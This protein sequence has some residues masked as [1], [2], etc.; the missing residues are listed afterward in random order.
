MKIGLLKTGLLKAFIKKN[1][2]PIKFLFRM[3]ALI[4]LWK[5]LFFITWRNPV[6]LGYYNEFSLLII[7]LLLNASATIMSF[8]GEQMEVDHVLRIIRIKDTV[9]V[10]VGEPCI[11]FEID[12][13]FIALILCS[14]G[15]IQNK[16]WYGTLGLGLLIFVNILRIMVLTYLVEIDPWLWEVNHKFVFSVVVY[17][18]LFF[19]WHIWI[20][21]FS[22]DTNH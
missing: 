7:D 20:K 21:R 22:S 1:S 9:G 16:L 8:L 2:T 4:F 10:T 5:V 14:K 12:A 11:G 3:G 13:L 19:L 18:V 6:L 15:S 17:S